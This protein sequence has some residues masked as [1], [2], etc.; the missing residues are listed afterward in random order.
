MS[1]RYAKVARDHR[2]WN[3]NK[4]KNK[5]KNKNNKNKK[6][7]NKNKKKKKKKK[8]HKNAIKRCVA[9]W[10]QAAVWQEHHTVLCTY[11]HP[12]STW[13]TLTLTLLYIV[14]MASPVCE[15]LQYIHI[16]VQGYITRLHIHVCPLPA[17]MG[18]QQPKSGDLGI[19]RS[20][21]SIPGIFLGGNHF[22]TIKPFT[23][24]QNSFKASGKSPSDAHSYP[25]PRFWFVASPCLKLK[26]P[27]LRSGPKNPSIPPSLMVLPSGN[28]TWLLNMAHL[29]LIYLWK[30]DKN[31]GFFHK[32]LSFPEANHVKSIEIPWFPPGALLL[33]VTLHS[34]CCVRPEMERKATQSPATS[35]GARL[36]PKNTGNWI[37]VVFTPKSHS[38]SSQTDPEK[39]I[40]QSI[41]HHQHWVRRSWG[42]NWLNCRKYWGSTLYLIL[43]ISMQW[44]G[45]IQL[46]L[47]SGACFDIW[48]KRIATQIGFSRILQLFPPWCFLWMWDKMKN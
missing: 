5:N 23:Y 42:T 19:P 6:N 38:N 24:E 47:I 13:T 26:S 32:H 46:G 12:Q 18:I 35:T 3:N 39:S 16:H 27:L 22:P 40:Y 4:N 1:W 30:M 45:S 44:P 34:N 15:A 37:D 10:L 9:R 33:V 8:T 21:W 48:G 43:H 2:I 36:G 11:A 41:E 29:Q 20:T 7:T 17:L 31:G 14:L 25:I 28:L